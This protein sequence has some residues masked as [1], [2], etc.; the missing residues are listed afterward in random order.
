MK[1]Y[2]TYLITITIKSNS[3]NYKI[4]DVTTTII[5]SKHSGNF[6]I[7]K[8]IDEIWQGSEYP[9]FTIKISEIESD[10]F[11]FLPTII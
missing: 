11:L 7:K 3:W 9:N 4:G 2:N 8:L 5:L 10:K 6:I 1:D